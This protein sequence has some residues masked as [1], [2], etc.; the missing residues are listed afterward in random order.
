MLQPIVSCQVNGDHRATRDRQNRFLVGVFTSMQPLSD[1][2]LDQFTE[3]SQIVRTG[4]DSHG[5]HYNA[6]FGRL[7]QACWI[8]ENAYFLL[9]EIERLRASLKAI[10]EIFKSTT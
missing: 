7:N 10:E 9:A 5:N 1:K 3:A 4:R 8:G 6:E 2:M